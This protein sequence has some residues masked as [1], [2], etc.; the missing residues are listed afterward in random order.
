MIFEAFGVKE[1]IRF[2]LGFVCECK[3]FEKTWLYDVAFK[4]PMVE[5]LNQVHLTSPIT[6][7]FSEYPG[8]N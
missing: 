8:F 6:N 2:Y 5:S 3:S 1:L 4:F 7:S